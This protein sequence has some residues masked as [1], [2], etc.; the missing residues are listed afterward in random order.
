MGGTSKVDQKCHN[1]GQTDLPGRDRWASA[2]VERDQMQGRR[3][4]HSLQVLYVAAVAR[5]VL[6]RPSGDGTLLGSSQELMQAHM[7]RKE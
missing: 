7:G 6:S 1:M 5:R 3:E 4:L 2:S